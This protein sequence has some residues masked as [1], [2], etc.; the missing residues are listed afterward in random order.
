MSTIV[1]STQMASFGKV[2]DKV[3]SWF[4]VMSLSSALCST[5]VQGRSLE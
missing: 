2:M 3:H 4:V 5:V 1:A